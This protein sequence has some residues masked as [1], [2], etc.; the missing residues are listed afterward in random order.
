[1]TPEKRAFFIE[2]A[3]LRAAQ[4]ALYRDPTHRLTRD[5]LLGLKIPSISW[6]VR[7]LLIGVGLLAVGSGA[8]LAHVSENQAF[9]LI[10]IFGLVAWPGI[11]GRRRTVQSL[12]DGLGHGLGEVVSHAIVHILD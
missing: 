3:A 12:V 7:A 1:M 9:W 10:A 8:A 4:R 2:K 5:E 11:T 6:P